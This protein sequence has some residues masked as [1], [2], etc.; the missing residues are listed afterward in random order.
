MIVFLA[1]T[2]SLDD[3][4]VPDTSIGLAQYNEPNILD[5][6]S[7]QPQLLQPVSGNG[8]QV[9]LVDVTATVGNNATAFAVYLYQSAYSM[10][11]SRYGALMYNAS[12][13]QTLRDSATILFNTSGIYALPAF[14]NLYN[15]ALLRA[16]TGNPTATI[17]MSFWGF[18]ET[19]STAP[20]TQ[21]MAAALLSISFSRCS[22]LCLLLLLP[23]CRRTFRRCIAR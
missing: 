14:Y 6:S 17:S 8:E 11:L 10:Q 21:A 19:V 12:I 3:I 16:I 13:G 22:L 2:K 5:F 20:Q 9:Q 1:T 7:P 18:P 23:L 4:S 15:T